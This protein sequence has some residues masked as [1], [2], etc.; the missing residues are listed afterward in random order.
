MEAIISLDSTYSYIHTSAVSHNYYIK[1][2]SSFSFQFAETSTLEQADHIYFLTLIV[3]SIQ[4]EP[5]HS[6][7]VAY[8]YQHQ[9]NNNNNEENIVIH[10]E[11]NTSLFQTLLISAPTM[12]VY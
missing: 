3:D 2:K 7:F 8:P 11:S 4:I 10:K 12:Y 9:N 6:N 5:L 1:G